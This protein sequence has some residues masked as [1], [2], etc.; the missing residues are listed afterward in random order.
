MT[1]GAYATRS[2][3]RFRLLSISAYLCGFFARL[4]R[5]ATK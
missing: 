2:K 4:R 5:Y 3:P 1:R